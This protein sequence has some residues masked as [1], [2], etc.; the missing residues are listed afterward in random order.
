M[1]SAL[2]AA[3][4]LFVVAVVANLPAWT[5]D[6]W[7]G[8][9]GRRVEIVREMSASGDLVAIVVG[10]LLIR[11]LLDSATTLEGQFRNNPD[12][13]VA[14]DLIEE[15]IRPTHADE[16]AIF[17]SEALT[18]NN[19][20]FRNAVEEFTRRTRD[21][22][23]E[24]VNFEGGTLQITN[25][26]ETGIDGFVSED[27]KTTLVPFTMAGDLGDGND[28]I[29]EPLLSSTVTIASRISI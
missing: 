13:Q 16:I 1:R 28:N 7:G 15:R 29:E 9:E 2:G 18:V 5:F 8:T 26:Y 23:P 25:F 11:S 27:G 12:S 6:G 22:G 20:V 24:V 3:F 10:V 19:D 4:V 14:Q 17:Q 21:L